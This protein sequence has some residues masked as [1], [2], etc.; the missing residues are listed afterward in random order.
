MHLVLHILKLSHDVLGQSD[1]LLVPELVLGRGQ[2]FER[3]RPRFL[4]VVWMTNAILSCLLLGFAAAPRNL[5]KTFAP[6]PDVS[7]VQQGPKVL[8]VVVSV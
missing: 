5:K 8:R 7:L 1:K 2:Q 3:V 4:R 6:R